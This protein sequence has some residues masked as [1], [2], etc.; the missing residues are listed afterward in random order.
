MRKDAL[1]MVLVTAVAGV[2][3]AFFRWL[4]NI[5]AFEP[6]TGLMI[7]YAK[8][9]VFMAAYMVAAAAVFA[10]LALMWTKRCVCERS[11]ELALHPST[12][13]PELMCKVCGALIMAL[14]VVLMFYAPVKRHPTLERIFAAATIFG[15]VAVILFPLKTDSPVSGVR[16]M[17]LV[18]VIFSC[19]WLVCCY[20]NNAENP[21][22]WAFLVE[23][24][25]II[26]TVMAWY[27]LA[28]YYYGRAKPFAALFFVQ[29]AAFMNMATLSDE[30]GAAMTA[31]FAA[32]TA[33]MLMFEF[34]LVKN[35]AP[36]KHAQH[37]K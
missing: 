14:G 19:V 18:P 6:D 2:F 30:R 24:L 37:A 29:G 36:H 17:S 31:M 4:E 9:T 25:A 26:A 15:G 3:G 32:Q 34:L 5:N 35:S 1:K 10:V 20:K 23:I 16:G 22:F 28:A 12:F 33:L 11:P 13:A 21:V 27:E 7:P 8:T